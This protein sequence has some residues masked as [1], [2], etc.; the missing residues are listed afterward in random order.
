MDKQ[1]FLDAALE[2][3]GLRWAIFPLLP[4]SKIPPKGSHGFLDATTDP[5]Q[6]RA[7]WSA[8][9]EANIGLAVGKS[10]LVAIDVD[11]RH[12]GDAT[13]AAICLALGEAVADTVVNMTG[14][15]GRHFL[16][17]QNG[18]PVK[19]DDG[20][21]GE[22]VDTVGETGYIILPPSVHPNGKA[23]AWAPGRSPF[24]RLPSPV[25]AALDA[26]LPKYTDRK[27]KAMTARPAWADAGDFWLQWALGRVGPGTRNKT[28][29]DL[30]CQ[31][32]DAGLI[33]GDAEGVLMQY[34]DRVADLGDH[35]YTYREAKASL[36]EAYS[37]PARDPATRIPTPAD[38]ETGEK[39]ALQPVGREEVEL[40]AFPLT[41]TGNGE[42]LA[43]LFGGVLRFAHVPPGPTGGIKGHWLIWSGHRWA[44][45]DMGQVETFAKQTARRREAA[46]LA[47]PSDT[48]AQEAYRK[49]ALSWALGSESAYRRRAMCDLARTESPIAARYTD[50]DRDPWLLGCRNGVL[51]LRT[52]TLRPGRQAD[53]VTKSVGFDFDP[54][55]P[56]P[57][58][59][60]FLLEI[61]D[62][63]TALV[64]FL[65]RAVGYS[66]TADTREQC[67]FLC[68]GSGA[69]GKT[70]LLSTL[71]AA[72]GDYAVNSPF[73][74]FEWDRN[75]QGTNDLAALAG[76]RLVTAAETSEARRLNEA[77]VKAITGGDPVTARF[78][79]SE[80]FTFVPG[81]KVWLAMNALP[82]VT[83]TDLGIWRRI[84]LVP[85]KVSFAG[86][87]DR[88][89]DAQLRTELPGIL[90]W[91]VEGCLEWQGLGTLGAPEAVVEATE[92]YRTQSDLV[93]R[94]LAEE[95]LV[96]DGMTVRASELYGAFAAWAKR[97]GEDV[98]AGTAFGLRMRDLGH[99]KTR[100]ALGMVY[101]GLGLPAGD[102][103]G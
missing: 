23:Y 48:K 64:G 22:G 25:P 89:L 11:P 80:F 7:W 72:F 32:R 17:R 78:L 47:L 83:G 96:R 2:Y 3:V 30:A 41:D 62:G 49:D 21:L 12:Q 74:T 9:P 97:Q 33:Q 79:F 103:S 94:F 63:D 69:N 99:E 45:V 100:N 42:S 28:G 31:L 86:R 24:E 73:S 26:R 52:G 19:T 61:F 58:W 29:F 92:A 53:L 98:M 34:V 93:G 77:R 70:T 1:T 40:N 14:G 4:R 43:A 82:K 13:W 35:P 84:R 88:T 71:R 66:L 16:Y 39:A 68:H 50:F 8:T 27:G 38:A 87:E 10:G 6:V 101:V 44:P 15:G 75:T 55:A 102:L 76:A 5:A 95:V 57:R 51:D 85:F 60:R 81:F 18:H 56:C 59:D 67:L 36:N 65:R 37:A 54:D 90:R 46:A 91:A 20:T